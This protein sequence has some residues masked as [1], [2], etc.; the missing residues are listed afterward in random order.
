[1]PKIERRGKQICNGKK[2]QQKMGLPLKGIGLGLLPKQ[3]EMMVAKGQDQKERI[4]DDL[5]WK[6]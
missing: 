5:M 6:G 4:V 3:A 1:M 2:Q